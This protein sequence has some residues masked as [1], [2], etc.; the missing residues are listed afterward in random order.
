M[1]ACLV[2]AALAMPLAMPPYAEALALHR[3]E[4]SIKWSVVHRI[5]IW[6]FTA[7]RIAER[8]LL[9]WGMDAARDLPGG[10]PT[11]ASLFPGA[12][13]PADAELLPLHP[14]DAV[15]EW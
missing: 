15:L 8:P 14:H 2:A 1:A 4:P 6:R 10:K 5:F 7:E 3:D 12:Q 11:V 13:I 9:G